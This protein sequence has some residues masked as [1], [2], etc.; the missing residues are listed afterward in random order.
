MSAV[1]QSRDNCKITT[2]VTIAR[3]FLLHSW[4]FRIDL[5]GHFEAAWD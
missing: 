4:G 3:D 5:R 2:K 1:S